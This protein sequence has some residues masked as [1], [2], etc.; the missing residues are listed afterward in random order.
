MIVMI[1]KDFIA[2][3]I[4]VTICILTGVNATSAN[5]MISAFR[6]AFNEPSMIAY[7]NEQGTDPDDSSIPSLPYASDQPSAPGKSP[8]SQSSRSS[9]RY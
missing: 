7:A 9:L 3:T 5:K 6:A 8:S 1:Y 2:A 4:A